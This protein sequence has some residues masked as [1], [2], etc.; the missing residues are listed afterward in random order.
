MRQFLCESFLAAASRAGEEVDGVFHG[1]FRRLRSSPRA[2]YRSDA[3][4]LLP[5]ENM[6]VVGELTEEQLLAILGGVRA[7]S[8][9]R[10]S[11]VR[12]GSVEDE[13]GKLVAIKGTPRRER[14]RVLFNSYDAQSGGRKLNVLRDSLAKPASKSRLLPLG[15]REA[16]IDY[17]ADL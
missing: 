17:V 4:D 3:W 5:Y 11:S 15:T 12:L 9:L 7:H 8:F 16:L 2:L 6:L 14:Y 1:T 10:P 13:K